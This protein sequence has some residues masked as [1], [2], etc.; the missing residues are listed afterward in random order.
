MIDYHI[1]TQLSGDATGDIEAA[2]KR[3]IEIGLREISFTEHVDFE[4]TDPAYGLFDYDH[5]LSLIEKARQHYS[6]QLIIRFGVEVD[7]QNRHDSEVR[8]FLKGKRFDYVLGAEHYVEGILMEEHQRLFAR[9]QAR[10]VYA[11]YFEN[12]LAVVRT[13]LFDTLAHFD[14]CKRHGV[15][16]SGPF[17]PEPFDDQIATILREVVESGMT[18]E[19][20]TSGLRQ[21]PGESYPGSRILGMYRELGGTAIIVGSD[22]HRTEDVGRNIDDA[23]ALAKNAGFDNVATFSNRRKTLLPI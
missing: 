14:V 16:Y 23:I 1:H 2:C 3:A 20:N 8:R 21:S 22:A 4:P 18:L 11:C 10:D 13:G 15:R 12:V 19:I 17:D 6:G 5:Y 7:Y 9:R